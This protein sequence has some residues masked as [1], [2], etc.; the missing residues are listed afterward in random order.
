MVMK[1]DQLEVEI[2]DDAEAMGRAGA[3]YVRT[4]IEQAIAERGSANVILATGNSQ[5]AFLK[6]LC[7]LQSIEWNKV[8]IFH[9]DEYIGISE[10]HPASFVRYIRER[11]VNVVHPLAFFPIRGDADDPQAVCDEY[12]ALLREY[13]ADVCCMGIGEN[14]HIAF[15]EPN[16][17]DFNDPRW[18]RRVTLDER[19]RAQQVGEGHFPSLDAVPAEA[20]SLTIPALL[21]ARR[22]VV[23]VPEARKA[24]AVRRALLGPVSNACPAS[25]LRT[26][27]HARLY[28]DQ[29]SARELKAQLGSAQEG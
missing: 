3:E 24:E 2:Y 20:I 29:D 10:D 28:L 13:P 17:A 14:G 5:L 23:Q 12:E 25:I 26:C 8:R 15:N 6:A 18:V 27:S 9:M 1:F 19:S 4:L 21:A 22:I 11:V 7:S 16:A